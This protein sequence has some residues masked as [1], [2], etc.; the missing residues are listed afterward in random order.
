[1]IDS[2]GGGG[3]IPLQP[4]YLISQSPDKVILRNFE[5]VIT[6]YPEPKNY[7]SGQ[8]D[9]YFQEKLGEY[10]PQKSMGVAALMRDD[11]F[12]LTPEGL[13]RMEKRKKYEEDLEHHSLKDLREKRD[14]L[15]AK[16]AHREETRL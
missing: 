2:P 3:K 14:L 6:S 4:N 10:S 13:Q 11:L 7:I 8:A 15:K 1:M 16:K 9:G 5:G 12:T